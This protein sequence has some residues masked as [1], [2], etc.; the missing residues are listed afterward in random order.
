MIQSKYNPYATPE[1][2]EQAYRDA[3]S[4]RALGTALGV[5]GATVRYWLD[6]AGI[7][8]KPRGGPNNPRG[9]RK[10]SPPPPNPFKAAQQ[11]QAFYEQ[12]GGEN[13]IARHFGVSQK[14]VRKWLDKFE[15][16]RFKP[17]NRPKGIT[18]PTQGG[19]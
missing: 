11:A 4:T 9:N 14:L 16:V 1:A 12:A 8:R 7:P 19:A 10:H 18:T 13:A 15:V 17:G 5:S 3:G 2:L 6:R